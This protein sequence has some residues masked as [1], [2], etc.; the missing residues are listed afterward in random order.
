VVAS[1][2]RPRGLHYDALVAQLPNEV[3]QIRN[4]IS[5]SIHPRNALRQLEAL[6]R[7]NQFLM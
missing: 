1:G 4:F 3:I 2:K 7:D 6:T 5:Q